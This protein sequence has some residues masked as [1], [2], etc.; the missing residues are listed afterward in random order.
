MMGAALYYFGL[1]S[2]NIYQVLTAFGQMGALALAV[3]LL[4]GS[5]L[6]LAQA[7]FAHRRMARLAPKIAGIC[8]M[9]LSLAALLNTNNEPVALAST[10][11]LGWHV[12]DDQSDPRAFDALLL[13]AR[14][15]PQKVMIDF[16]ADWC[17]A[18]HQLSNTTFK[19]PSVA[20][21]LKNYF[22]IKVDASNASDHV[23]GIEQRYNLTG[24]PTLI[25]L[26]ERGDYV[27]DATIL[28]FLEPK[29]FLERLKSS[30]E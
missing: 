1:A 16:Y 24:L 21:A 17:V 9:T 7:P 12:I 22:L 26:D 29:R 6:L 5:I 10:D 4:L 2:K 14:K 11:E 13:E 23:N 27:H 28:G 19:D 8:L 3:N 30:A 15:L 25:F 20:Q 18:C